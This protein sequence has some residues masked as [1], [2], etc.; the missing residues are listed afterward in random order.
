MLHKNP[1]LG[2]ASHHPVTQKTVSSHAGKDVQ[3]APLAKAFFAPI[4]HLA[5]CLAESVAYHDQF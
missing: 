3:V 1:P 2:Y 4:V 5:V